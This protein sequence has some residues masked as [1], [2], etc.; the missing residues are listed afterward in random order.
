MATKK[1]KM[2]LSKKEIEKNFKDRALEALAAGAGGLGASM[3]LNAVNPKVKN[4]MLRRGMGGITM[5]AGAGLGIASGNNYLTAFSHGLVATGA[6]QL[7][8][9]LLPEGETV[10]G[11][12][13][14]VTADSFKLKR[15]SQSVSGLGS[16][17]E[18][19]LAELAMLAELEIE[20]QLNEMNGEDDSE[21]YL[22]DDEDDLEGIEATEVLNNL[23]P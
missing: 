11:I 15:Y 5:A 4:E 8:L 13:A 17:P 1:M 3:G 21:E 19:E 14:V 2:F 7:A 23:I 18:E 9:D 20:E 6:N 16:I 10:N 12:G 22:E